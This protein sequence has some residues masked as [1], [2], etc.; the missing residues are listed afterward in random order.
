M[1]MDEIDRGIQHREKRREEIKT[2]RDS[3]PAAEFDPTAARTLE[4]KI[5]TMLFGQYHGTDQQLRWLQLSLRAAAEAFLA[6]IG[7]LPFSDGRRTDSRLDEH[8]DIWMRQAR[9][10]LDKTDR[11]TLNRQSASLGGMFDK[12]GNEQKLI[13]FPEETGPPDAE[14]S[15]LDEE[16]PVTKL[17]PADGFKPE[18]KENEAQP[19]RGRGRPKSAA[20]GKAK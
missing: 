14:P 19:K 20:K 13:E 2:L 8:I 4:K 10:L 12:D 17:E 11:D 15:P 7:A 16:L 3:L 1:L 5:R 6:A 18:D 9:A